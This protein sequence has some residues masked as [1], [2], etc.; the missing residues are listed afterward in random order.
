LTASRATVVGRPIAGALCLCWRS[1]TVSACSL[2][3]PAAGWQGRGAHVLWRGSE[4]G[5]GCDF[6][7]FLGLCFV[8]ACL[9]LTL[10][11]PTPRVHQ[12]ARVPKPQTSHNRAN[13]EPIL[14]PN[15]KMRLRNKSPPRGPYGAVAVGE[16][17]LSGSRRLHRYRF[18]L[19][20]LSERAGLAPSP[21]AILS[22]WPRVGRAWL[23]GLASQLL[24][25][26]WLC[27]FIAPPFAASLSIR[28]PPRSLASPFGRTRA[29]LFSSVVHVPS[30]SF[31]MVSFQFR[32]NIARV[33][34]VVRFLWRRRTLPRS[35]SRSWVWRVRLR[36]LDRCVGASRSRSRTRHV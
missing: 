29:R 13:A 2:S 31:S 20:G 24:S 14:C 4:A 27:P 34:V 5:C 16:R 32:I 22:R 25:G 12:A 28:F 18:V 26:A 23:F 3:F 21:W 33:L 6:R 30:S 15:S 7:S 10:C 1:S 36:G 17:L 11:R 35:L 8:R 9:A 19:V